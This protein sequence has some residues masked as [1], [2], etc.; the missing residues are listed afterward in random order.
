LP[1]KTGKIAAIVTMGPLVPCR[2]EDRWKGGECS[3][4]P[5]SRAV[6]EGDQV[7]AGNDYLTAKFFRVRLPLIPYSGLLWEPNSFEQFLETLAF[8]KIVETAVDPQ[9]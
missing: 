4:Y 9:K 5:S 1:L 7:S 8:M 3:R 2:A 6:D